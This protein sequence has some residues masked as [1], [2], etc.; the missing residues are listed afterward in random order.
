VP[1]TVDYAVLAGTATAGTDFTAATG[2]L[3]FSPGETT[4]TISVPVKADGVIEGA[5][6]FTVQLSN[7]LGA[8]LAAA[9]GTGTLQNDDN[10]ELSIADVEIVEDNS[11]SRDAVLT[12]LLSAA[13]TQTVTVNYATANGSA[14][15]GSD[16][17]AR[18]GTLTFAPGITSQQI[19]VP[20]IGDTAVEPDET[21]TVALS[22][23]QNATVSASAGTATVIIRNDDLPV[24]SVTGTEIVEGNDGS[25][26][27]VLTVTLSSAA[28]QAVTVDFATADG[29]ATAGGDYTATT[30]SLTFEPGFT[31][32]EIRI[33]VTGDGEV[34]P[35]ETFTV[36]LSNAQNAVVSGTAGKATVTIKNDDARPTLS[37]SGDIRQA[38]GGGEVA[39]TVSLSAASAQTVT[40]N[41][42]TADGTATAGSDYTAASG[43]LTFAPGETS[44]QFKVPVADDTLVEPD[45]TFTVTL[46][47]AQNAAIS[48][49]Q[50][51]ATVTI[52]N[53]DA[54]ATSVVFDGL[55]FSLDDDPNALQGSE[56]NDRIDGLGGNDTLD[57]GPGHDSLTG[58]LGDD[59]LI[60][61]SGDAPGSAGVSPAPWGHGHIAQASL[62][63]RFTVFGYPVG[64]TPALPGAVLYVAR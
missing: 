43:I 8:T 12:V 53:D 26:E 49:T 23:P 54:P 18:A 48:D 30:G 46:S 31:S 21:F 10:A 5:E 44:Q 56:V 4:Q 55:D 25:Q 17:T 9:K 11:G 36:S 14:T 2:S 41:Y 42:A 61:G 24:L 15:A 16:Y 3:T 60:G 51:S 33:P 22:N 13:S 50:G 37:L 35:D 34:E 1:V 45:E 20:V 6:T 63:A 38:E 57:G 39:V 28:T 7:P 29:T 27:A 59:K 32:R 47:G 19:K 40:V 64:E 62:F 58:G 52:A